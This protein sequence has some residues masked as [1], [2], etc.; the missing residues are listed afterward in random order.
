MSVL[1]IRAPLGRAPT[2]FAWTLIAE[3]RESAGG[4]G[5]LSTLPRH[6]DRLQ[7]VV[8]ANDMLITRA[9]LPAGA[10]PRGAALAYAIEDRMAGDPDASDVL[11]L[12]EAAA[13]GGIS[14][15]E[16]SISNGEGGTSQAARGTPYA[17]GAAHAI[18]AALDRQGL[19]H[20]REALARADFGGYELHSEILLLPWTPGTWTL[21]WDGREG[22]LRTGALEGAATDQGDRS[23]APLALRLAL[24]QADERPSRILV[25]TAPSVHPGSGTAPDLA[26]WEAQLGLPLQL[27]GPWDWRKAPAD[28]GPALVSERRRWRGFTGTLPRLRAAAW[29]AGAALALHALFAGLNWAVLAA[30]QRNLRQ[31]MET[32]FRAEFPDA[33]AVVD[34]ALQMR[35][36]LAE[37]RHAAGQPDGGDFLPMIDKVAQALAGLPPGSLRT[38]SFENGRMSLELPGVDET[39]LQRLRAAL[40]DR[41][42]GV[43]ASPRRAGAAAAP[44]ISVRAL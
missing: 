41:G 5:P 14:H 4:E 23:M 35:R 7:L 1:R 19:A 9:R 12:G 18:V 39:G 26:A 10:R 44:V 17:A 24:A 30:E 22:V 6:A 11:W 34:P 8:P 36:K 15:A 29:L 20:W 33:M 37:A 31:G 43:D 16:R 2:S 38:L 3:G 21:A 28:A 32:R 27:A 42:L 13:Q 40:R 25:Y